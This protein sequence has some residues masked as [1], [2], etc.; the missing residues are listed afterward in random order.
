MTQILFPSVFGEPDPHLLSEIQAAKLAGWHVAYYDHDLLAKSQGLH[1]K[2]LRVGKAILRGWMLQPETYKFLF[3]E[4]QK[5]GVELI[6]DPKMYETTHLFPNAY[7]HLPSSTLT[8]FSEGREPDLSVVLEEML[9]WN[10]VFVKDY[11]KSVPECNRIKK[12]STL[13]EAQQVCKQFLEARGKLFTK[14]FVFKSWRDIDETEGK[15]LEFRC[16]Y[17][18]NKLVSVTPIHGVF[19]S[20]PEL[21]HNIIYGEGTKL[22]SNFYTVDI[23]RSNGSWFVMECGDGGVSGLTIDMLPITFY[24][25]LKN[26]T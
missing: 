8:K 12:W 2:G 5:L 17:Y 13:E 19:D 18:Y 11:V 9:P 24:A 20:T 26:R 3:E 10:D 1:H 21:P 23:A 16:F 22:P 7:K 25:E 6:N 14:G 15:K 4:L